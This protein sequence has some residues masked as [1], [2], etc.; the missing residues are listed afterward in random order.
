MKLFIVFSILFLSLACSSDQNLT[1]SEKALLEEFNFDANLFS[2]LKKDESIAYQQLSITEN[3]FSLGDM[4]TEQKP[5]KLLK[6][7]SFPYNWKKDYEFVRRLVPELSPKGYQIFISKLGD[8]N[9]P[10]LLS[11]IKSKNQLDI[12]K[13]IGTSSLNHDI[14][15]ET[16]IEKIQKWDETHGVQIYS[17]GSDWMDLWFQAPKNVHQLT[18][19]IAAFVPDIVVQ[20]GYYSI[21][22]LRKDLNE[23]VIINFWW[24]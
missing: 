18:E 6:G 15:N 1:K 19:E 9:S 17:A 12:L 10:S 21:E 20:P 7:I 24:D 23:G 22:D 3:V 11:V 8:E 5:T 13:T 2:Q 16:L 4:A 14:S